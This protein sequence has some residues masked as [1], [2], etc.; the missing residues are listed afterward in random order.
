[1]THCLKIQRVKGQELHLWIYNHVMPGI[2]TVYITIWSGHCFCVFMFAHAICLNELCSYSNNVCSYS[3]N[4][5]AKSQSWQAGGCAKWKTWWA[6]GWWE[7]CGYQ[8]TSTKLLN[9]IIQRVS[10]ATIFVWVRRSLKKERRI[11]QKYLTPFFYVYFRGLFRAHP[12]FFD[13]G[14]ALK[15]SIEIC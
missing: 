2:T 1:M 11:S 8:V 12:I 10:D 14:R 5:C 9:I 6:K 15:I 7:K 4:V 13:I 3:N